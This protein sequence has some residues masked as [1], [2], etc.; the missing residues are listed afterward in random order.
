MSDNMSIE[1]FEELVA[2]YGAKAENWPPQERAAMARI[3]EESAEASAILARAARLDAVLDS[4]LPTPHS[5]L[6]ARILRDMHGALD[7]LDNDV[8]AFPQSSPRATRLVWSMTTALAAC[9]VG[10]I[11][12]GPVLVETYIGGSDLMVSLDIINDF[13]LST[14]PL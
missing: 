13:F 12:A 4:A 7:S 6:Q 8:I 9:F 3:Q 5:D 1:R 14:E 2:A 11:I 10:G